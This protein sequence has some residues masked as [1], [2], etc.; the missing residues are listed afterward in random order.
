[1]SMGFLNKSQLKTKIHRLNKTLSCRDRQQQ[2]THC[3]RLLKPFFFMLQT[4]IILRVNRQNVYLPNL[5]HQRTASMT[6]ENW[7]WASILGLVSTLFLSSSLMYRLWLVLLWVGDMQTWVIL[8]CKSFFSN[9]LIPLSGSIKPIS[10]CRKCTPSWDNES[11]VKRCI[12]RANILQFWAK[13]GE[14]YDRGTHN[15][16]DL[17]INT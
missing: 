10:F 17:S 16:V 5:R 3:G 13:S 8:D 2:P 15:A 12:I 4:E 9:Y 1:M 6:P 11:F 14:L 7:W